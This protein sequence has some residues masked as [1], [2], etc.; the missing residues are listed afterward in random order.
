M[1]NRA[2]L[3]SAINTLFIEH[4]NKSIF[5]NLNVRLESIYKAENAII[6]IPFGSLSYLANHC[7]YRSGLFAS[8]SAHHLASPS[9]LKYASNCCRLRLQ[10][11]ECMAVEQNSLEFFV[12]TA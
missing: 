1:P 7:M 10:H 3:K 5:Q 11:F 4:I 6:Y 12:Q 2:F 8:R 9:L